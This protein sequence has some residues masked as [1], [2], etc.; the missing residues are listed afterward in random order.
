[1]FKL[2]IVLLSLLSVAKV[3]ESQVQGVHSSVVTSTSDVKAPEGISPVAGG[4]QDVPPPIQPGGPALGGG[5]GL[6]WPGLG[7]SKNLGVSASAGF[8]PFLSGLGLGGGVPP[9]VDG[10]GPGF[11]GGAP[12]GA[13][14]GFLGPSYIPSSWLGSAFGAKGDILFPIVIVIFFIVGVWTV[15]QFLLTLIVPLIAAK[16]GVLGAASSI[17]KLRSIPEGDPSCVSKEK[18]AQNVNEA[19]EKTY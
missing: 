9:P 16:V 1:M 12:I 15:I 17:K 5:P 7:F 19:I 2:L 18:L 10:S 11:F 6:L 3:I 14:G 8:S 13:G 4:F